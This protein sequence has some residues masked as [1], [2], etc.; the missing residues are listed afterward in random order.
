MKAKYGLKKIGLERILSKQGYCSRSQARLLIQSGKVLVNHRVVQNP[1]YPVTPE[2][3]QIQVEGQVLQ[4]ASKIYLMLN[5]PRGCVTT[6]SD[7]EG[8]K[9]VYD[10]LKSSPE[11]ASLPWLS[12]V[13]RLDKASEGLLL[14]SN[15]T[16]WSHH[17]TAPE[18]HLEKTYHVQIQALLEEHT[19]IQMKQGVRDE[20]D[21]LRVKEV[22]RLRQGE[23]N[24]WLEI[25]LEEGKNRHIRR[26]LEILEVEVLRLIRVS[27]GPLP[28]GT[29]SKGQWRFLTPQEIQSL[30]K[31][32]SRR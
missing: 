25:R 2:S 5:K 28:L 16:D 14:F 17:I 4:N 27:V 8:K 21:I 11:G 29:L 13:G 3:D 26:L 19:L 32:F 9:T 10:C 7:E 24:S 1:E 15:D 12:P 23:R 22:K 31:N 20:D 6:T 18:S 30:S